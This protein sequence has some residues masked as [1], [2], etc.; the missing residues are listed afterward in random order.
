[1]F[2]GGM[3]S[4]KNTQILLTFVLQKNESLRNLCLHLFVRGDF[5]RKELRAQHDNQL[6]EGNLLKRICFECRNSNNKF[7]LID[8]PKYDEQGNGEG[9][10]AFFCRAKEGQYFR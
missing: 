6:L 8:L 1:M 10:A 2:V 9:T 5:G 3:G 4:G 7:P